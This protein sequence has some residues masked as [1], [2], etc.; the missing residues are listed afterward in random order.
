MKKH[1]LK[2]P[3]WLRSN[4][5]YRCRLY[6]NSS[7]TMV[8]SEDVERVHPYDANLISSVQHDGKH[9]LL[10][11][12]DMPHFYVESSSPGH[13]HLYIKSALTKEQLNEILE[14]L[15]K[16]GIVQPGIYN[17]FKRRGWLSLRLPGQRK[18]TEDDYELKL[19][20]YAKGVYDVKD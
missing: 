10:L 4:E 3:G 16:Y 6:G 12:L 2:L 8:P 13:G 15:V 20:K 14:P 1:F 19:I 9:C 18:N 7:S 5:F 17:G 11:D